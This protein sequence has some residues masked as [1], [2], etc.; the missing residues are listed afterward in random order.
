MTLSVLLNLGFAGGDEPGEY[1]QDTIIIEPESDTIYVYIGDS[2]ETRYKSPDGVKK[3]VIDW[4]PWLGTSTISSVTWDSS[5]NLTF[6]D[7]SNTNQT[8]TTYISGGEL[9]Q[10]YRVDCKIV[11]ADS[12]ART[13]ERSFILNIV[14]KWA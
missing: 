2:M 9:N 12:P 8:A 6:G 4:S 11:T 1:D 14:R 5:P 10:E 7:N 3:Q 13:E